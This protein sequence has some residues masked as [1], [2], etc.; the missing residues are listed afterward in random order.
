MSLPRRLARLK[1][2]I[3]SALSPQTDGAVPGPPWQSATKKESTWQAPDFR[4]ASAALRRAGELAAAEEICARGISRNPADVPL[5][6]EHVEIAH[7]TKDGPARLAR[8]QHVFDLTAGHAPARAF[9][10]LADCHRQR[11]DV[12]LAATVLAD[13]LTRHPEEFSLLEKLAARLSANGDTSAA[14]AAWTTLIR[15][16]PDKVPASVYLK[17]SLAL[18]EEGLLERVGK[19][20]R[21]GLEK[22]PEDPA[23]LDSIANF[24]AL[25]AKPP[26]APLPFDPANA[27]A[28]HLFRDHFE[29][30]GQGTV[31]FSLG[32]TAWRQHVP[33]MLDFAETV[34]TPLDAGATNSID[35][36]TVW[37]APSAQH[38]PVLE[39]AAAAGKPLLYL[40]S[41]F[42]SSPRLEG[43][44]APAHS[45]VISPNGAH[46]DATRPSYFE[47]TLNSDNYALTPEQQAR[48]ESCI[49]AIVQHRLSKFNHAPRR[50]MRA[51]FPADGTPRILLV[52]QRKGG[53]SI[54]WSLGGQA[55]FERMWET[56]LGMPDYQILVKLHPEVI[57][58][59]TRSQFH[60]L[61]PDPLPENVILIDFDVNP[62]DLFD[63][64]DQVFV[65]SSQLGFE[66]VLAGKEVH[67]FAAPYYAGWGFTHDELAIPRRKS[68]RTPAE[69]FH[70]FHIAHSR[71]FVPDL[72]GAD[73]EDL[74]KHLVVVRDHPALAKPVED[75]T[76]SS[77]Q[78][79]ELP[80]PLKILMVIPSGRYGATGRYLQTLSIS[81]RRLGCEIMILAEGPCQRLE[82]GVHWITLNFDG[83]RLT[84]PIRRKIV[85]FAPHFIYENGVRSRAQRA[86]LEAVVITG[87]RFAM[88]SEDDDVQI[89]HYRQSAKAAER[90]VALDHPKLD[91]AAVAHFLRE[92][93]WNHSLR[94]FLDPDFNRWIE[95]LLRTVCYRMASFHS[96]IWHPFADRL[97]REY[98]VPTLVVPPVACAADFTR[99]AMTPDEREVVL[100]RYDI[101]PE[102]VVIF[103]GGALYNYSGEFAVF[104]EA[105]NLAAQADAGKF[106][107]VVASGRTSLPLARMAAQRLGTNVTF[108]DIGVASDELYMEMLKACDVVCSPGVPDDFNRYRLPS[109]LVK[110]MAMAKPILTC[111]WG[112]GE[113]LE[114]NR[115]AFLTDGEDPASWA[116]VITLTG[117][118]S[119][120]SEVGAR[121]RDFALEHFDAVRVATALK[122]QFEQSLREAPHDLAAR[123]EIPA[124][125]DARPRPKIRLRSRH[126][127]P[128]QPAIHALA[129]QTHRLDTVV[130]IG[131]GECDE[132]DDYCRLG[133]RRI[134]LIVCSPHT[135]VSLRAAE[136]RSGSMT[137]ET[138]AGSAGSDFT[139]SKMAAALPPP[140]CYDLLAVALDATAAD[141]VASAESAFFERFRWIFLTHLAAPVET[142]LTRIG[143]ERVAL[144]PN[145]T[146]LVPAVF[147]ARRSSTSRCKPVTP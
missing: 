113:S 105:L 51:Q 124:S 122:L 53:P 100:R 106:A 35:V 137:C 59:R 46:V 43:A 36:F 31:S 115:N 57:A 39:M 133:A 98:A 125:D 111:R 140:S 9:G 26:D 126:H 92:N 88:Q 117:D 14:I 80:N 15:A 52:D 16:H 42:L 135:T 45:I 23:L 145:H 143:F 86:A 96:A 87:A 25:L 83:L 139:P 55:T 18:R 107:L 142:Q 129:L 48:A 34:P 134:H 82:D 12:E 97:A 61:L 147:F 40:D 68:R 19:V 76:K 5:A 37:G 123:I 79:D 90:L 60:S 72:P 114:H 24:T 130:H 21:D 121:G 109:R 73:I 6:M 32:D 118:A 49:A 85:N 22:H 10:I 95:P 66:A 146:D 64:V 127:S 33:T 70:L 13:G 47:Q 56:A 17:M 81:L 41:G 104:L 58:G 28:A 141:W 77:S 112:F 120:R 89:H 11:G 132:L 3:Y 103:I 65:C 44:D 8:C 108:A 50:D 84:E 27:A 93:D 94:V 91:I 128:L 99:I 101:A 67:C 110:A 54:H 62:H 136:N 116:E 38:T 7:A 131:T 29:P 30:H 144:P 138:L 78:S 4:R 75:S 69:V 74:I 119:S 102:S 1:N 2:R 20:L 63:V 71:Y